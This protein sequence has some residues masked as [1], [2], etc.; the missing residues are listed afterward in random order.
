MTTVANTPAA[1]TA[2]T[3]PTGMANGLTNLA[4]N[5][6]TFI[7]LLTTQLKNQNPT[8]PVDSNQFTQQ[9]VEFASVQQ[10]VQTNTLLQQL[11]NNSTATQV[12]SASSFVGT[13]IEAA[14]NQGAL[15]N[16]NATFGYTLASSASNVH[17]SIKDSSGNVVFSGTGTTNPGSNTVTWDGKN[18]LTGA[19]EPD[20]TY[21]MSVTATDA[22]GASITATPFIE[23]KVTSASIAN[24]QVMLNIGSLQVPEGNVTSVTNLPGANAQSTLT[25][26]LETALHSIGL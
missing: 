23:G 17:V 22:N 20:G 6:N 14:G 8:S 16:G 1:A 13:T 12:G 24:G 21:T 26:A 2:N 7:S 25:S 5:F 3:N 19:T 15:V 4:G 9:L 11:V 18:S 10:Q